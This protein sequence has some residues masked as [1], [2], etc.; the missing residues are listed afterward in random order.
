MLIITHQWAFTA[1]WKQWV[2]TVTLSTVLESSPGNST[3]SHS[4]GAPSLS[5]SV[6]TLHQ[7]NLHLLSECSD[8]FSLGHL[9]FSAWMKTGTIGAMPA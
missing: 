2:F 6:H 9:E 7:V 4:R 5:T 8:I 3:G 1:V